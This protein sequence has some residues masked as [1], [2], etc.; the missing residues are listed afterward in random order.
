MVFKPPI[1]SSILGRD[2]P[3]G[4]SSGVAG[5]SG[6]SCP[7]KGGWV[8]GQ[9]ARVN[10]GLL[11]KGVAG[12]CRR[13]IALMYGAAHSLFVRLCAALYHAACHRGVS[14]AVCR[15]GTVWWCAHIFIPPRSACM[16]RHPISHLVGFSA[17]LVP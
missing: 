2:Q 14:R 12:M 10:F 3:P 11:Q 7:S 1:Y 8:C 13:C 15:G 4:V 5:D 16:A 6:Q 9:V 17:A